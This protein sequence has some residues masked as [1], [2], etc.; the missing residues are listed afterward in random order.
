MWG[1]IY[2]TGRSRVEWMEDK[3]LRPESQNNFGNSSALA[4]KLENRGGNLIPSD[5]GGVTW[6]GRLT[7]KIIVV[8]SYGF[9]VCS[10]RVCGGSDRADSELSN[11]LRCQGQWLSKSS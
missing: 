4:L 1:E 3:D 6:N 9:R 10:A 8:L 5:R 2:I 7:G 11:L